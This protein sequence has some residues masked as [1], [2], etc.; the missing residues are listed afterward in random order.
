MS[1]NRN[2]NGS[3]G[4]IWE[5]LTDF[6]YSP[7]SIESWVKFG[8]QVLVVGMVI[9]TLKALDG[10]VCGQPWN[11]AFPQTWGN[12]AGCF[13]RS[14]VRNIPNSTFSPGAQPQQSSDVVAPPTNGTAPEREETAP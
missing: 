5:V 1:S 14:L 2:Y 10:E 9:T 6:N 7:S 8:C 11:L 12:P 4:S 3:S 13:V